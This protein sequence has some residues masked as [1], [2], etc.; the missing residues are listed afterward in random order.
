[1][2]KATKTLAIAA[3]VGGCASMAFAQSPLPYSGGYGPYN[4]A[5]GAY[6]YTVY[7]A[8]PYGYANPSYSTP[9]GTYPAWTY[10][11]D[12]G[13]SAQLRSDFNRGVYSPGR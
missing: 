3:F 7:P 8:A 2:S 4:Y 9:Y 6:D 1:M 10:D 13:L 11:P 12:P 5:P